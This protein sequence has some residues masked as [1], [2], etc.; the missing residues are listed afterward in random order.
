[1]VPKPACA[2]TQYWMSM[3]TSSSS[4]NWIQGIYSLPPIEPLGLFHV[5]YVLR[6][7]SVF[8]QYKSRCFM[9]ETIAGVERPHSRWLS[10][11]WW[12]E[13]HPT[14]IVQSNYVSM[15]GYGYYTIILYIYGLWFLFPQMWFLYNY[16]IAYMMFIPQ[17]ML[18]YGNRFGPIPMY[19][20]ISV[21][22][23]ELPYVVQLCEYMCVWV[24][25]NSAWTCTVL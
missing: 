19:M 9:V 24:M 8:S 10:V 22:S 14:S 7:P 12:V 21:L 23:W 18:L 6:Y 13:P 17:N 1:M 16:V 25:C 3:Q 11:A 15:C 4:Q 2:W 5:P 20:E